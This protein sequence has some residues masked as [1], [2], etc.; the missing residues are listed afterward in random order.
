MSNRF[1]AINLTH[2]KKIV[3]GKKHITHQGRLHDTTCNHYLS[4]SSLKSSQSTSKMSNLLKSGAANAAL[5]ASGMLGSNFPLGF[6]AASTDV[7]VFNLQ[8]RPALATLMVCCSIASWITVRSLS[9]TP[10]NSSMQHTPP[11][12]RTRAPASNCQSPPPSR[13]AATVRPADVVPAKSSYRQQQR[14]WR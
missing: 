9:L 4:H 7:R 5:T 13:V 3:A 12:A 14:R 10:P 1:D 2:V 8:T 11:S 6:V